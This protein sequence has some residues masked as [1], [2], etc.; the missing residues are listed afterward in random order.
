ML[1]LT[2][3]GLISKDD[4]TKVAILLKDLDQRSESIGTYFSKIKLD[5]E[6]L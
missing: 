6:A 4:L 1:K 2:S 5:L 3:N